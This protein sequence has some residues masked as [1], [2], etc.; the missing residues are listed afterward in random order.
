MVIY[1]GGLGASLNQWQLALVVFV[2]LYNSIVVFV[3][4]PVS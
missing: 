3:A 4:V 1:A 2:L